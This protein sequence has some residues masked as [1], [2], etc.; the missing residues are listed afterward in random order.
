MRKPCPYIGIH[1]KNMQ[2]S[3]AVVMLHGDC[4][5]HCKFCITENRIQSMSR[6][7]YNRLL[8]RLR[9]EGFGNI[10][11][12]GGEP[13]CWREGVEYAAEAAKQ[14]GFYVQVGTNGILMP[15]ANRYAN[16][17]DR[18]VLPLDAA[19]PAGHDSLRI[20]PPGGGSHYQIIL[21]RLEQLRDWGYSVT[22]STV[23]SRA[24]L[25]DITAIGDLLADYVAEGGRLHAWHLYCFVPRGRGGSHAAEILGISRDEF[26]AAAYKAQSQH[27]PYVIY[28]RPD[29][30]HSQTVDFFWYEKGKL[31]VGSEVWNEIRAGM[32]VAQSE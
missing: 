11:I 28:K 23:V 22:V 1:I 27:Y 6:Q 17:V 9:R 26:N 7:D 31:H 13:F 5:M 14:Q 25:Q 20:M 10:V 18:Y 32:P 2:K 4:N 29:M 30:R 16:P 8:M 3:I 19:D 12:G 15:D 21:N 24:N